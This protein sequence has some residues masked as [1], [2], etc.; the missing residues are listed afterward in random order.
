[1][2]N[3]FIKDIEKFSFENFIKNLDINVNSFNSLCAKPE[4]CGSC[5]ISYISYNKQLELKKLYVQ[6][7]LKLTGKVSKQIL[8]NINVYPST[9]NTFYRGRMDYAVNYEGLL[10]L[11][12]K[13][14]WATIIPQHTCILPLPVIKKSFHLLNKIVPKYLHGYDRLNK[15]GFV[16]FIVIRGSLLRQVSLNF[17][18]RQDVIDKM[19]INKFQEKINKIVKIIKE[20]N[21]IIKKE[22]LNIVFKGATVSVV[23]S[24][25]EDSN[26]RVFLNFKLRNSKLYFNIV[27]DYFNKAYNLEEFLLSKKYIKRSNLKNIVVEEVINGVTYKV[28]PFS[29]FQPNHYT[30]GTLQKL[31]AKEVFNILSFNKVQNTRNIALG[32]PVPVIV[33]LF[34]GQGFLGGFAHFVIRQDLRLPVKTKI[35]ELDSKAIEIGKEVWQKFLK[36]E[37]I[38]GLSF[39][40]ADAYDID[41]PKAD[42]LILD[43]PRRGLTRKLIKQILNNK[44]IKYIVYV[45]C[46]IKQFAVEFKSHF[47]KNFE[48]N[49]VQIVDQFPHTYHIETIITM[50]RVM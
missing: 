40:I 32:N 35:I 12:Q 5:Q 23:N 8:T 1:M 44:E 42:I 30:S 18:I 15:K 9:P 19:H 39:E 27:N 16:S 11:K 28:L 10:G 20:F 13:G 34:G 45:S 24:G 37:D 25:R 6:E 7:L 26:G 14:D 17:V 50:K 49:K 33:D 36:L 29:F 48:I 4:E 21:L 31:V 38:K 47:Y 43:P 41:L 22:K 3:S 46:N 2:Q